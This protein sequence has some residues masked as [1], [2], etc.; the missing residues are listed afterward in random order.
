MQYP[1][2]PMNSERPVSDKLCRNCY[3]FIHDEYSKRLFT[4]YILCLAKELSF[5]I[6]LEIRKAINSTGL[7]RQ[8]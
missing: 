8:Q 5:L 3:T 4:D 2:A 6:T 7:E 1:G